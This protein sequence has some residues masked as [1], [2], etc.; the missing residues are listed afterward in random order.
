MIHHHRYR[1]FYKAF[2]NSILRSLWQ[3][4]EENI[5]LAKEIIFFC[6]YNRNETETIVADQLKQASSIIISFSD[7]YFKDNF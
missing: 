4:S 7:L 6:Y 5:Y 1:R 2:L 3:R